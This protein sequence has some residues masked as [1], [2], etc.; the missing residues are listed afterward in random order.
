V[1]RE[2]DDALFGM[3]EL[4]QIKA[5]LSDYL[6]SKVNR[7][8][9]LASGWET[10]VFEFALER[11]SPRFRL[12]GGTPLVLRFYDGGNAED[13]GTREYRTIRQL[14][15][16]DYCVPRP[17]VYERERAALGVPFLIMERLHGG[18]LFAIKSFPLAFKTFS[19]GFWSFVRKQTVLHRLDPR[20]V[21]PEGAP[22]SFGTSD[23]PSTPLLDRILHTVA[24]RVERGPLPYLREALDWARNCAPAFTSARPALVHMDYHPQNVLVKGVRVTGVIDWVNADLG[25]RHLDA[26][27]TAV[28]LSTSAMEKPRWM[29]DNAAGNSL[30]K[31]FS[32]LYFPLYHAMAPV[33]LERFRYCQGVAALTRL[34]MLGMMR[35]RGPESVGFRPEAIAEVTPSVVRLMSCYL[36]RK[37]G[38]PIG[39]DLPPSPA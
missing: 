31:I 9:L 6:G 11:S 7:L 14:S 3:M 37:S 34:S 15:A 27:T 2:S 35:A 38:V 18:P 23:S 22:Q 1:G 13:K 30:R 5:R 29:R 10:T 25:D 24:E 12:P 4:P 8:A 39:Q 33:E 21:A 26:A 32:M 19:L 36:T 28:I 17:Y 20:S 16:A